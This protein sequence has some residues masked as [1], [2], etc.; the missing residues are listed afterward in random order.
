[1]KAAIAQIDTSALRHDFR[2]GLPSWEQ[3]LAGVIEELA[4]RPA[5]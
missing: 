4:A 1:M 2:I 3:G 5:A